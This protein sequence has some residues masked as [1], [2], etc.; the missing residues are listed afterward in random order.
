MTW[1]QAWAV[2]W[3]VC[4]VGHAHGQLG[5]RGEGKDTQ[6]FDTP[7]TTDPLLPDT[8]DTVNESDQEDALSEG[9]D[10]DPA[11]RDDAWGWRP[12]EDT[13]QGCFLEEEFDGTLMFVNLT[14]VMEIHELESKERACFH[15]C[16]NKKPLSTYLAIS[17]AITSGADGCGC[18]DLL[19]SG[20]EVDSDRC[21]EVADHYRVYCGPANWECLNHGEMAT[22]SSLLLCLVLVAL[23]HSLISNYNDVYS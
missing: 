9:T 21:D 19:D 5:I 3:A 15:M 20:S 7:T 17:P 10:E 11:V 8:Q 4:L 14:Q 6:G 22:V 16:R 13:Y 18:K 12:L 2:A 23:L 1:V